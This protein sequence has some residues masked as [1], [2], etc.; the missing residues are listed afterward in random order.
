[1]TDFVNYYSRA[2]GGRADYS[3][4][5]ISSR[6]SGPSSQCG[7]VAVGARGGREGWDRHLR[8]SPARAPSG[9]VTSRVL[10]SS[11]EIIQ[12]AV[13]APLI[14]PDHKPTE[15]YSYGG[16]SHLQYEEG[17]LGAADADGMSK[18]IL[19]IHKGSTQYSDSPRTCTGA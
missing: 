1:M 2:S 19:K 4:S 10:P 16:V 7:C 14:A 6:S 8:R 12:P 3:I 17:A 5:S 9:N 15:R 18:N 11:V 13:S